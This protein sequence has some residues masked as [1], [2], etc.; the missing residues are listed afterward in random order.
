MHPSLSAAAGAS[1][2]ACSA[3]MCK[4]FCSACKIIII[5]IIAFLHARD[6]KTTKHKSRFFFFSEWIPQLL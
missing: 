5:I 3:S 4:T 1:P 2:A 6:S